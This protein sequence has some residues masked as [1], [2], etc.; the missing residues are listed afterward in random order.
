MPDEQNSAKDLTTGLISVFDRIGQFFHLFDLSFFVSG[1]VTFGAL[2]FLYLRRGHALKFPFPDWVGVIAVIVGCYVCGLLAFAAGRMLNGWWRRPKKLW[3]PEKTESALMGAIRMHGLKL[4]MPEPDTEYKARRLYIR[5]WAEIAQKRPRSVAFNL[6]Q[7]YWVM[8]AT[9]DGLGAAFLVWGVVLI[10][11]ACP[12]YVTHAVVMGSALIGFAICLGL[13]ALSFKQG[14]RY[15]AYQI[16]ELVADFAVVHR[17][18]L[19]SVDDVPVAK[20]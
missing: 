19:E 9:Y 12:V 17:E 18:V 3:K 15:Y 7:R 13:S 16:E 14:A 5:M 4:S 20:T 11:C 8:A 2:V 10:V 1:V 6:L